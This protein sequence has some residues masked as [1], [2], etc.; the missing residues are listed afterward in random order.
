VRRLDLSP[1]SFRTP[2]SRTISFSAVAG[3]HRPT[4][5]RHRG[6]LTQFAD[7]PRRPG[8]P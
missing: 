1:C 3:S 5:D 8:L 2:F 6:A 4:G 7:D